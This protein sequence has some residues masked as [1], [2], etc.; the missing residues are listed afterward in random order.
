MRLRV[1]VLSGAREG[2]RRLLEGPRVTVGRHP[3]CDLQLDPQQ[4]RAASARHAVFLLAGGRWLVRDLGSRNGTFVGGERLDDDRRLRDGDV[5]QFGREGPQVQVELI[6]AGTRSVTEPAAGLG[7]ESSREAA[8]GGASA[9]EDGSR[10]A[11]STTAALRRQVA[12]R[13]RWLVALGLVLAA[14][15]LGGA[16]LLT[17]GFTG[18]SPGVDPS[19]AA[20]RTDSLVRVDRQELDSLR[21]RVAGLEEALQAS[22]RR[23]ASIQEELRAAERDETGAAGGSGEEGARQQLERRLDSAVADLRRRS[24]V[25]EVDFGPIESQHWRALARVFVEKSDGSVARATGFSVRPSGL[26]VTSRHAVL[27]ADGTPAARLAVQFAGS[28]QVWPGELVATTDGED[29]ALVRARNVVGEV[30]TVTRLDG[31]PDTLASGSPVAVMGYSGD[32]SG[33]PSG[34]STGRLPRPGITSGLLL[35]AGEDDD[36]RIRGFGAE[37]GSGSPIFDVDGRLVGVLQGGIEDGGEGAN[38]KILVAVPAAAVRG[39]LSTV[40]ERLER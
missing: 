9:G 21:G 29:L 18:G 2:L 19:A 20:G 23:V 34:S 28:E 12:R 39:L 10:R 36:L 5:V 3:D 17:D 27:E 30:P 37:G 22:R 33:L 7:D 31:R 40:L 26:L 14:A 1:E 15:G 38:G 16:Y 25:A 4:D 11:G 6:P 13:G 8:S 24:E 32:G 35:E